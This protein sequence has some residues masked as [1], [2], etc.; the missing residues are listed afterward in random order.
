MAREGDQRLLLLN[1]E[2]LAGLVPAGGGEQLAV[3][4]EGDVVDPVGVVFDLGQE[5][6]RR[7]LVD[8]DDPVGSGGG[9]FLTVGA[10]GQGEHGV[11]GLGHIESRL[12]RRRGLERPELGQTVLTGI[13]AGRGQPLAVSAEGD[14][15][16]P[17]WKPLNAAVERTVGRLPTCQFVIARRLDVLAVGL[18][19]I[20]VIGTATDRPRG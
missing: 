12:R 2:D 19:A 9:E 10:E 20:A 11:R 16:G 4:A 3:G 17:L 8:A 15:V 14:V 1:V 13:A 5:L 18:K 6:A 7:R